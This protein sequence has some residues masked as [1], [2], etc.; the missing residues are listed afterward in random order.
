MKRIFCLILASFLL[1]SVT[2][3]KNEKNP[4]GENSVDV[5]Y[6]VKMGKMPECDYSLGDSVDVLNDDLKKLYDTV[7]EAVYNVVEGEETVKIDS[8]TFQYY[9]FK[10]KKADGIS[11]IVNFDTAYSF[12]IGTL[13]VEVINALNDFEYVEEK[14]N[15]DN[16][17]FVLGTT[18]GKVI[19]YEFANNTVSFIFVND[20]LFATAIY[21]TND[22]K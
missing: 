20:A 14:F 1:I 21:K 8:G 22:W 2:A 7:E 10:D 4:S 9:Y 5:E 15:D 19:K 16:A 6:L 3:C 13:S 17:F 12:N 11:Y 18:D